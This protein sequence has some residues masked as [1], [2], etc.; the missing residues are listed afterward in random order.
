MRKAMELGGVKTLEG[1]TTTL[2]LRVAPASVL[3]IDF[4]AVPAEY[5]EIR[6]EVV[7]N[8]DA[9]K[10]ALKDGSEVPGADLSK[11]NFYLVRR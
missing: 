8:K 5:K 4:D 1:Q 2:S 11:G 6:T 3:I 10:K 9:V 7:I